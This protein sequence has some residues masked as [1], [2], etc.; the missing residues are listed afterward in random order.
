MDKPETYKNY[1]ARI[2]YNTRKSCPDQGQIEYRSRI[3]NWRILWVTSPGDSCALSQFSY[4]WPAELR[5]LHSQTFILEMLVQIICLSLWRL[6]DGLNY[7]RTAFLWGSRGIY[8]I[9]KN[10]S[11]SLCNFTLSPGKLVGFVQ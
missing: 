5:N 2:F 9:H 10:I 4:I 7:L 11:V 6:G 3:E 8:I 1:L